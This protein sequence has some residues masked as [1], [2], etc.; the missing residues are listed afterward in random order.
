VVEHR[1]RI[2]EHLYIAM[3]ECLVA[4]R[5]FSHAVTVYAHDRVSQELFWDLG[6]GR[7]CIDAMRMT[8]PLPRMLSGDRLDVR[9]AKPEDDEAIFHLFTGMEQHLS[10]APIF[11]PSYWEISPQHFREHIHGTFFQFI[12]ALHRGRPISFL[13]LQD[14]GESFVSVLPQVKNI[15]GAYTIPQ[16]RGSGVSAD[17]LNWTLG[18]LHSKGYTHCGVDCES[19][20]PNARRFWL[21][22]FT[23]YTYSMVRRIDERIVDK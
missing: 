23:P 15:T 21:K 7:R 19:I 17:L 10:T 6:F 3:A 8:E 2:Y 16:E 13:R 22:Y 1:E 12:L 14:D 4:R 9:L 11:M 18:Y 20:N 5:A